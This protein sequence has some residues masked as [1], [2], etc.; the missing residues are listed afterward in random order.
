MITATIIS[1]VDMSLQGAF[2]IYLSK[3]N[4]KDESEVRK[5]KKRFLNNTIYT[6]GYEGKELKDVIT[7]LKANGIEYLLD[8]R[9][10]SHEQVVNCFGSAFNIKSKSLSSPFPNSTCAAM[11]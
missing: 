3:N 6:I 5:A 2:L 8:L 10:L 7:T 1:T 9:L 4:I 11:A